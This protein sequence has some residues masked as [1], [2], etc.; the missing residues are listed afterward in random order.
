MVASADRIGCPGPKPGPPPS[1]TSRRR[2]LTPRI[3]SG[4][5]F[6]RLF[7]RARPVRWRV[8]SPARRA[9]GIHDRLKARLVIIQ[10]S[11]DVLP[12]Q[13]DPLKGFGVKLAELT[14]FITQTSR[15][16]TRVRIGRT[17]HLGHRV[18]SSLDRSRQIVRQLHI[19][20]WEEVGG[21]QG[22]YLCLW[23]QHM[24]DQCLGRVDIR[25]GF[26]NCHTCEYR[27]KA[28]PLRTSGRG[29][30]HKIIRA[31]VKGLGHTRGVIKDNP[32]V[33]AQQLLLQ[34]R[35][36]GGAGV[37]HGPKFAHLLPCRHSIV[38]GK[39]AHHTICI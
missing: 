15:Q 36:V 21:A 5:C 23:L 30:G 20:H 7:D 34:E 31:L 26:R 16:Q 3:R 10:N 8:R 18:A 19:N 35:E 14:T 38:R 11:T 1:R 13:N 28:P 39:R 6:S 27:H 17:R 29:E 25:R 24:S 9:R 2:R 12:G 32:C 22:R 4:A 33:A 37:R